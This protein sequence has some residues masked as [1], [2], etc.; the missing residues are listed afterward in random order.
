MAANAVG[1]ASDSAQG[2]DTTSTAMAIGQA[3]AGSTKCHAI[4]TDTANTSRQATNHPA[5]LSA[6]SASCGLPCPARSTSLTSAD[7]VLSRA[8]GG[9]LLEEYR[10]PELASLEADFRD[11]DPH[12]TPIDHGEVCLNVDRGWFTS[13]R[14]PPPKTLSDLV[15]N[16]YRNLLVVENPATSSPGLAFLLATIAT[17]GDRWEAYWRALRANGVLAV[18]GW[19]EAYTQ[20]FSGASGSPGKRPI[21]VSYASSPAAEVIFASKPPA[22]APTAAVEAGCYRQVEYAGILRGAH[23]EDG[24]RK[25]IDFMLSER[26]QADVPGSMFVYPVRDG[27]PLPEEFVKHAIVPRDPLQLPPAE[28]DANRDRWVARWTEIVVR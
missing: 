8:V 25:L 1:V 28:V 19:E 7:S 10:S 21:V 11:P 9:N 26:F 23:N 27:V 22:T 18:D 5:T 12:V 16:S 20:Q 4:N 2:Q 24:A 17:Y 3:R 13:H 6:H 14:I 15:Q